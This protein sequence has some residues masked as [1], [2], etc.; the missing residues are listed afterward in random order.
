MG[1]R[2]F[3]EVYKI[4]AFSRLGVYDPLLKDNTRTKRD[5]IVRSSSTRTKERIFKLLQKSR[6]GKKRKLNSI[7]DSS[8]DDS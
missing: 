6:S 1:S 2:R 7:S 5:N 3:V 4:E 8:S